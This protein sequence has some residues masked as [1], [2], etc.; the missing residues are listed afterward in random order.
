MKNPTLRRGFTLIEVLVVVAIIA[1]LISILM[2]S[3]RTARET[4]RMNVCK[5]N[6]KQLALGMNFY[7]A[8]QKVLPATQSTFYLNS[9]L[10]KNGWWGSLRIDDLARQNWVWDGAMN[11]PGGGY[12]NSAADLKKFATDC[13]RRGTI[14][15]YTRNEKVYLCPSDRPGP[16]EDTALGGG[17]NGRSSYSMS[18]YIGYKAPEKLIR[19]PNT[20]GWILEDP[21]GS[22]PS[23]KVYTALTWAPSQM[24]L[25]VEEHPYYN[26]NQNRE[27]NFNV[28]DRIVTRHLPAFRTDRPSLGLK[29]RSNIAYV[30]GHVESPLYSWKTTGYKL[31]WDL[32]FPGQD[33]DFMEIFV[34][35]LPPRN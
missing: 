23:K 13:P 4:A 20:L 7:V 24:F 33:D 12:S 28:S 1:L 17:G 6:M 9:W 8:E 32:G 25:L 5:S 3:L 10:F 2:P 29:G 22:P 21:G 15:K 31:Y 11:S 16:P 14:F 34:P 30:D 26:L 35:Q 27:G 19:P 18:A